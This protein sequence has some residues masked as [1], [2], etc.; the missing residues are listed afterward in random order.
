MCYSIL[1]LPGSLS[2]LNDLEE[3][4][5]FI[6]TDSKN[7][8]VAWKNE[9]MKKINTLS[10]FPEMG[11]LVPDKKISSIGFRMFLFGN[12]FAFVPLTYGCIQHS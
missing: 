3:I 12:Y 10:L 6:S 4:V 5:L 8:A 7:R 11:T 9:L 2:A 1:N